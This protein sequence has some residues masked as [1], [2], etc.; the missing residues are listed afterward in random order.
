MPVSTSQKIRIH[1]YAKWADMPDP[2]YR[3]TLITATGK[4]SVTAPGFGQSDYD[5]AMAAIEAI[6]WNRIDEAIVEDPRAK[7]IALDRYYF[8]DN[9]PK[10][11]CINSRI[12]KKLSDLWSIL[13][14]YLP[15]E[16]QTHGYLAGIIA[17]AG[18]V[19]VVNFYYNGQLQWENIPLEAGRLAIEGL[20]DRL[21]YAVREPAKEEVPF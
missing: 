11:G 4:R 20:K 5:R 7:G 2:E 1:Q 8:R 18:N 3:Q 17:Q 15:Q 19:C 6:L 13:C 10:K 12:R 16:E 14:D 21:K 9:L